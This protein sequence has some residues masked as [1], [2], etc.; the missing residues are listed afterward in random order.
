MIGQQVDAGLK[1][2]LAF[3][4]SETD[5]FGICLHAAKKL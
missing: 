2:F 1:Q 5:P 3:I 4:L